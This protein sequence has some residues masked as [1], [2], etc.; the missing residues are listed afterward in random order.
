MYSINYPSHLIDI[1]VAINNPSFW[2]DA[3]I[4]FLNLRA[5]LFIVILID[6]II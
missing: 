5:L 6:L 1:G 4:K 2:N 3:I